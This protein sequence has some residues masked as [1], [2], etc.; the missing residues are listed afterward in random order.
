MKPKIEFIA[1]AG[2]AE[3]LNENL[4]PGATYNYRMRSLNEFGA[5]PFTPVLEISLASP[6]SLES[7]FINPVYPNPTQGEIKINV[8]NSVRR[9]FIWDTSGKLQV[10][11]NLI[12][13]NRLS[14]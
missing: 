1:S 2:S 13:T 7:I 8:G 3:F 9:I 12:Q 14:E 6:L 5:S 11:K 10:K 4:E